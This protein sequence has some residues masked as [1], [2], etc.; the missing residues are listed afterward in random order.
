M[1]GTGI[2]HYLQSSDTITHAVAYL[3]LAMSVA[4]WCFLIVKGWM[5]GRA[6]R[7][8]ARGLASAIGI[9]KAS[10]GIGKKL[11]SAK[12]ISASHHAAL[13]EAASAITRW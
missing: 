13:G 8:A 2:L 6:K 3:L 12:A 10:G 7:Q 11:L 5:L 9:S 1:A 4:S